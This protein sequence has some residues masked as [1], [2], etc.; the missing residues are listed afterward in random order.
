MDITRYRKKT[1]ETWAETFFGE[2]PTL[3]WSRHWMVLLAEQIDNRLDDLKKALFYGDDLQPEPRVDEE[4]FEDLDL[5]RG[6]KDLLHAVLGIA[7]EAGELMEAIEP[8]LYADNE[9]GK[10]DTT[11][12]DE[13][14]GDVYYY[15]MRMHDALQTDPDETMSRNLSKLL[16][17]Y[18]HGEF[19]TEDALN[20]DTDQEREALTS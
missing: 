1:R 11:N 5:T 18:E 17:R 12:L 8:L 20:R 10:I 6:Q 16:E 2:T 9:H 15:L 7:T 3:W 14:M 19:N 4:T 13:E